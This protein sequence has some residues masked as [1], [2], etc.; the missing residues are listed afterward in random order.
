[1]KSYC[2]LLRHFSIGAV[3]FGACVGVSTADFLEH[4]KSNVQKHLS[5]GSLIPAQYVSKNP[6]CLSAQETKILNQAPNLKPAVLNTAMRAYQ[7]A[8]KMGLD[9]QGMLTIIDYSLPST[10]KRLWVIDLNKNRVLDYTLV[11]NGKGSGTKYSTHFSNNPASFATSIGVYL[12][13]NTYYGAHGYSLRLNGLDR[14]FNDHAYFR[15]IVMHAGWYVSEDFIKLHGYLGRSW[16]CPALSKDVYRKVISEIK[17]GSILVAYYP[18]SKWLSESK[19][20]K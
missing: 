7:H 4:F 6:L 8:C 15:S 9:H 13:G 20:L 1:M 16:G 14:G 12:T 19:F 5:S 2:K 11:A 3:L 17:D 18:D 10:E